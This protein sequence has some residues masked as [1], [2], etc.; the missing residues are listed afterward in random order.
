MAIQYPFEL[1]VFQKEAIL[2]LEKVNQTYAISRRAQTLTPS[3]P[4]H[5]VPHSSSPASFA[6]LPITF[7]AAVVADDSRAALA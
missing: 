7:V 4:L 5:C 6:T 3:S 2:H 1:D